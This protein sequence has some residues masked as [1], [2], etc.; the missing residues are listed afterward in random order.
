MY[1]CRAGTHD[2]LHAL[3]PCD[4][5]LDSDELAPTGH[6]EDLVHPW[7]R[8]L[9]RIVVTDDPDERDSPGGHDAAVETIDQMSE[10]V[11][12]VR[13]AGCA[14]NENAVTVRVE[15]VVTSIRAFKCCAHR[16]GLGLGAECCF[17][18]L[19][20]KPGLG[21]DDKR[22]SRRFWSAELI[23]VLFV[24][25]KDIF[26]L[27]LIPCNGKGVALERADARKP[28]VRVLTRLDIDEAGKMH[29]YSAGLAGHRLDNGFGEA[30][31]RPVAVRK[32]EHASSSLSD[33]QDEDGDDPGKLRQPTGDGRGNTVNKRANE[34]DHCKEDMAAQER[35]VK[36]VSYRGDRQDQENDHRKRADSAR[37]DEDI[38]DHL[39]LDACPPAVGELN[40]GPGPKVNHSF[41]NDDAAH[42]AVKKVVG[43]EADLEQSD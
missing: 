28:K 41:K 4:E 32:T 38:M 17:V 10:I 7:P 13:D 8:P 15:A 37:G 24:Y 39:V 20:C 22:D 34:D 31:T 12:L 2:L 16:D 21:T 30:T 27:M 1:C 35:L 11:E 14:R 19:A 5:D 9:Q 6:A 33:P 26:V 29:R 40:I 36:R 43:V 18:Q 3:R 25:R 23:L 42:P